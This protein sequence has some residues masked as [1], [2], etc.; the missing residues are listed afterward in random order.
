MFFLALI[1]SKKTIE[2][3]DMDLIS[4]YLGQEWRFLFRDLGFL[5]GEIDQCVEENHFLGVKETIY[6]L[7]SSW[8]ERTENPT[9]GTVCK[10]LWIYSK[11]IKKKGTVLE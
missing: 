9:L 8:K 10:I 4:T 2:R 1:K 6:R 7:L 5:D 11:K 3:R